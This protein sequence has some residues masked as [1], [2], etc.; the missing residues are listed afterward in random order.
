M[1][2]AAERTLTW[3]LIFSK[4]LINTGTAS[5]PIVFKQLVAFLLNLELLIRLRNTGITLSISI[6]LLASVLAA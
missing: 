4:A 6:F 5:E 1:V 2:A 3:L